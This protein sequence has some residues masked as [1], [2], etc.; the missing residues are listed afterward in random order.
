MSLR[1]DPWARALAVCNLSRRP[2]ATRFASGLRIEAFAVRS[3]HVRSQAATTKPTAS[4][5][6]LRSA[7]WMRPSSSSAWA[8]SRIFV[9]RS[10]GPVPSA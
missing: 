10:A 5:I 2:T 3:S 1:L 6:W 4:R 8:A 9:S 7:L